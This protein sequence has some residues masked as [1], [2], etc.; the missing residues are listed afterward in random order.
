MSRMSQ[1]HWPMR[2]W[3][4]PTKELNYF[5]SSV[6]ENLAKLI[7][8]NNTTFINSWEEECNRQNN[9]L[10]SWR[11]VNRE[12]VAILVDSIDIGRAQEN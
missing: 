4:F 8:T 5:F 9:L 6:G 3:T 7:T 2:V 1:L 12:E 11:P 10:V